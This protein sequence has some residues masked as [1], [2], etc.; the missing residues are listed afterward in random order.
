MEHLCWLGFWNS[1]PKDKQM[2][3]QTTTES[4]V[5]FVSKASNLKGPL[6]CSFININMLKYP[7]TVQPSQP[8]SNQ[9][10]KL[11]CKSAICILQEKVQG[12][13]GHQ[14]LKTATDRKPFVYYIFSVSSLSLNMQRFNIFSPDVFP[15]NEVC[16]N[17]R[18]KTWMLEFFSAF[19][20]IDQISQSE[21]RLKLNPLEIVFDCASW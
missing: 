14:G 17:R 10:G 11:I 13:S 9:K 18:Q 3:K 15:L 4:F 19:T 7:L 1:S 8:L 16:N 2:D 12:P 5:S 20:A 6:A 21:Q